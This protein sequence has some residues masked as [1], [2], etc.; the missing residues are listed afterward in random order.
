MAG[1]QIGQQVGGRMIDMIRAS[2]RNCSAMTLLKV[3]SK[4]NFLAGFMAA[5]QKKGSVMLLWKKLN[6]YVQSKAME[7][8]K[9]K[10]TGSPVSLKIKLPVKNS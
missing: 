4:E 7:A 1:L 2:I 5:L 8:I 6:A 9:T 3:I 10:A